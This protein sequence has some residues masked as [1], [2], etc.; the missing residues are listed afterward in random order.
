MLLSACPREYCSTFF[1]ENRA[2]DNSAVPSRIVKIVPP[3]PLTTGTR[4]SW[5]ESPETVDAFATALYVP[6]FTD[7]ACDLIVT[8][9]FAVRYCEK[10]LPHTALKF[11]PP[12][13]RWQIGQL[14]VK[15]LK[16]GIEP[17]LRSL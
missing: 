9:G 6:W 12:Y 16:N 10:S 5:V 14:S 8:P 11:S 15:M 1:E 2:A 17:C 3:T 4:H 7:H 13:I